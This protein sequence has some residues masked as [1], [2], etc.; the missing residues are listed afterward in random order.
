MD[1]LSILPTGEAEKISSAEL[2]TLTGL[3]ARQLR[4]AIRRLR[5]DGYPVC[6]TTQRGGG[7]W[8]GENAEE[9]TTFLSSMDS[10]GR[11]VFKAVQCTRRTL[12]EL[13][14]GEEKTDA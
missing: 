11:N 8:I 14:H 1:L 3:D 2:Q 6:S 4:R 7:Y 13:Q 5:L 12:R 10:R 9:L